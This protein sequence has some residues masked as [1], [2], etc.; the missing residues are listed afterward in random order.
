[1]NPHARPFRSSPPAVIIP[2]RKRWWRKFMSPQWLLAAAPALLLPVFAM[3]ILDEP[4]PPSAIEQAV[5]ALP[6]PG[7]VV[8]SRGGRV[9]MFG[10]SAGNVPPSASLQIYANS[11][12]AS[13]ERMT[14]ERVLQ[15]Q[16]QYAQS[17]KL[18]DFDNVTYAALHPRSLASEDLLAGDYALLTQS[19]TPDMSFIYF[20]E[21]CNATPDDSTYY[22]K[23]SDLP[24]SSGVLMALN[25]TAAS[26]GLANFC[27]RVG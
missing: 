18:V 9:A 2:R 26:S 10:N 24:L 21:F 13:I 20:L 22:T 17:D 5:A 11:A 19:P 23:L 4:T 27:K 3:L 14:G 16:A 15:Q 6:L 25:S 7:A 8:S 12:P 1:M